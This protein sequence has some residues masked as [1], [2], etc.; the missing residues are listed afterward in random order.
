MV[1]HYPGVETSKAVFTGIMVIS[2]SSAG[3]RG[4]M[5][6][7]M[8]FAEEETVAPGIWLWL[9]DWPG[10]HALW[11]WCVAEL[12][13]LAVRIWLAMRRSAGELLTRLVRIRWNRNRREPAQPGQEAEDVRSAG[14]WERVP[15]GA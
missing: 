15:G 12:L 8:V 3:D 11:Y 2:F 7:I 6:I 9:C 1:D 14:A 5:A 10:V 4:I 13:E